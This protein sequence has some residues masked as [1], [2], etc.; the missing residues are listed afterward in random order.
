LGL[1]DLHKAVKVALVAE[2]L[3]DLVDKADLAVTVADKVALKVAV[4]EDLV[5]MAD[6]DQIL[7][8]KSSTKIK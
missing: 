4:L 1:L 8:P 2:V 7:W 6:N 3:G 5:A